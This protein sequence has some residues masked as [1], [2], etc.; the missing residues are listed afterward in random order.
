MAIA[1]NELATIIERV[2][3]QAPWLQFPEQVEAC[4][5]CNRNKTVYW[6]IDPTAAH[7]DYRINIKQTAFDLWSQII[8]IAPPVPGVREQM[9]K[10]GVKRL[11][12]L[13]DAHACYLGVNR[14]V[15]EDDKGANVLAF[16]CKPKCCFAYEPTMSGVAKVQI[17]PPDV[18]FVIYVRLDAEYLENA[19]SYAGVVTHWSIVESDTE[20]SMT[21]RDAKQRF[22]RQLW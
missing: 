13:C 19:E 20:D 4:S 8:G 3:N 7:A 2:L 9:A 22:S 17:L 11:V 14:P 10:H 6:R 5:P 15:G 16:V 18:V 12:S 21:P 1:K